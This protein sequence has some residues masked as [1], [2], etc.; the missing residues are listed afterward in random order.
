MEQR[1]N[2]GE[3]TLPFFEGTE[4]KV[5]LVVDSGLPSL[6]GRGEAYWAGVAS[7]AGAQVLS[8]TSNDHC[9]A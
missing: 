6:R 2:K 7:R 9:D 3:P 1:N 5:E 4:K 8:R